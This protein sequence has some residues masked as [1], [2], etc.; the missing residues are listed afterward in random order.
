MN[1]SSN[2][3]TNKMFL[4]FS[5]ACSCCSSL[6][7]NWGSKTTKCLWT[8]ISLTSVLLCLQQ[9][10]RISVCRDLS[11]SSR[12]CVSAEWAAETSVRQPTQNLLRKVSNWAAALK[13]KTKTRNKNAFRHIGAEQRQTSNSEYQRARYKIWG[14]AEWKRS[15]RMNQISGSVCG[16][17]LPGTN[18]KQTSHW[19]QK[20]KQTST[21][22]EA[23]AVG[24]Q[25]T[26][27]KARELFLLLAVNW[28]TVSHSQSDPPPPPISLKHVFITR[29]FLEPH[30]DLTLII[31]GWFT[32][33]NQLN[34]TELIWETRD[35]F[36]DTGLL[37]NLENNNRHT[38]YLYCSLTEGQDTNNWHG[39][40]R[41]LQKRYVN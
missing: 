36:V 9:S 37:R 16:F 2:T 8:W 15:G 27:Q 39:K 13:L 28:G 7:S 33:I 3:G 18:S 31:N 38:G 32:P 30:H 24:L 6:C 21:Q 1:V 20:K 19:P 14:I 22:T 29:S 40:H 26:S 12:C 10:C 35:Q 25:N 34:S 17:S 5:V 4:L 41:F 11:E 23:D